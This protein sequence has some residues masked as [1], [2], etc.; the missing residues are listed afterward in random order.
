M[1]GFS[2]L[3]GYSHFFFGKP[4]CR[5]DQVSGESSWLTDIILACFRDFAEAIF[6]K[7]KREVAALDSGGWNVGN[8]V[9]ARRRC[10][11]LSFSTMHR[12]AV[13][14]CISLQHSIA[15]RPSDC[16]ALIGYH[17]CDASNTK[18]KASTTSLNTN[19]PES[20]QWYL[21]VP[22]RE[23]QGLCNLEGQLVSHW[24]LQERVCARPRPWSGDKE[25]AGQAT[26]LLRRGQGPVIQLEHIIQPPVEHR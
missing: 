16:W 19:I 5:L 12:T 7:Q 4:A 26:N 25:G 21:I 17:S 8:V 20:F 23:A 6:E 10:C 14:L 13:D 24:Q 11:Y 9:E 18:T 2:I 1:W 15:A 22:L 3:W